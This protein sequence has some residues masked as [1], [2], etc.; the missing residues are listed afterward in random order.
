MRP[1]E[2]EAIIDGRN[3]VLLSAA[4]VWEM[5]IKQSLGRLR[6]PEP[7]WRA[8]SR[9]GIRPLPITFEHADAAG[10]L[11]RLHRDPFDRM[12]VAQARVESL[13]LVT[14]DPV[15]G[16]YKGVALLS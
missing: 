6:L 12:L 13:T 3:E 14:R 15:L 8:T 4:S 9:L 11:P 10:R 1:A 5:A 7:V 16:R 2:R